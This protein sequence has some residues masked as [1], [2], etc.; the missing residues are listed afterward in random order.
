METKSSCGDLLRGNVS[1]GLLG[2]HGVKALKKAAA[3]GE[4]EATTADRLTRF[5]ASHCDVLLRCSGFQM[6]R[7]PTILSG[8][9]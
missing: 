5:A 7:H 4:P 9:P 3:Q 2:A 6:R 8:A 1:W